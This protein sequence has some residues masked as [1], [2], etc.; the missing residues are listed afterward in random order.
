MSR[1][2]SRK[3]AKTGD[4]KKD[5]HLLEIR[6]PPGPMALYQ[7]VLHYYGNNDFGADYEALNMFHNSYCKRAGS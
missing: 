1:F 3:A 7:F 5:I 2:Q 4:H 6:A